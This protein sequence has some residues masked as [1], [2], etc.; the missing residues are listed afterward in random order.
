M[1]ISPP[2]VASNFMYV[3]KLSNNCEIVWNNASQPQLFIWNI[4]TF[5]HI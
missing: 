4:T 3:V 1:S 5:Q 2:T